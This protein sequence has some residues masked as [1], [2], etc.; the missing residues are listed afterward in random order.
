MAL[1]ARLIHR[2]VIEKVLVFSPVRLVAAQAV[3]RDVGIPGIDDLLAD[4]VRGMPLPLVTV[5]AKLDRRRF[6]RQEE[7]VGTVWRVTFAALAF[8]DRRVLCL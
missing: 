5:P 1:D 8:G 4:R 6:F 3:Q 7:V 2:L